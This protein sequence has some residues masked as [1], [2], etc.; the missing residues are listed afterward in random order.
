MKRASNN[1][2][3]INTFKL[4]IE[5]DTNPMYYQ[6]AISMGGFT[7]FGNKLGP[8]LKKLMAEIV[9]QMEGK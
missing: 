6:Y 8:L 4:K 2:K 5:V 9:Q 7:L 3:Q 1:M